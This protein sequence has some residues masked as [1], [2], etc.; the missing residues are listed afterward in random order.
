MQT[1]VKSG[2]R[3]A[4][5]HPPLP[6]GKKLRR[7]NENEIKPGVTVWYNSGGQESWGTGQILSALEPDQYGNLRAKLQCEGKAFRKDPRVSNMYLPDGTPHGESFERLLDLPTI[8]DGADAAANGTSPPPG[9]SDASANGDAH[10]DPSLKP[11]SDSLDAPDV[12]DF[13]QALQVG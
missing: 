10:C 5:L 4:P 2:K 8:G 11:A 6:C 1:P 9:A 13:L 3:G 7:A 12:A